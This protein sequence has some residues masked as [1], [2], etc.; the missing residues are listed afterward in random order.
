MYGQSALLRRCTGAFS[1]DGT[2]TYG[3]STAIRVRWEEGTQRAVTNGAET[4]FATYRTRSVYTDVE[5]G[6]GDEITYLG[7]VY[8]VSG[9]TTIPTLDGSILYW[10]AVVE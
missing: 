4:A 5:L 1:A 7:H 8:H 10:E 2:P 9:V 6:F 3:A